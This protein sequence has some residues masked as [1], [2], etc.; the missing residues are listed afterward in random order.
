MIVVTIEHMNR[1]AEG[2][3]L[4]RLRYF[5]SA[6]DSVQPFLRIAA[7]GHYHLSPT[8]ARTCAP[9]LRRRAQRI[10]ARRQ[11]SKG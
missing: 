10:L 8:T 11:A 5:A 7:C 3:S 6:A 9:A 2:S 4:H 1:A